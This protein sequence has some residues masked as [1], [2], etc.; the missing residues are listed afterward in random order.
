[1]GRK[2]KF[3]MAP[4]RHG[5][6]FR[7]LSASDNRGGSTNETAMSCD[8][9]LDECDL[10]EVDG[11]ETEDGWKKGWKNR[12]RQGGKREAGEW[13][14]MELQRERRGEGGGKNNMEAEWECVGNGVRWKRRYWAG[15]QIGG[16]VMMRR[17]R[18]G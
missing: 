10:D 5:N 13:G 4:G 18:G 8:G 14:G 16:G 17:K 7:L 6:A 12:G 1:M 9:E 2:L 15:Q 3:L 11:L